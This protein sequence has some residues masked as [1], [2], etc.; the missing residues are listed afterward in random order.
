MSDNRCYL[1]IDLGTSSLKVGL[2]SPE[3]R[4]LAM[5]STGVQTSYPYPGWAEQYP[6]QWWDATCS[7]TKELLGSVDVEPKDIASIGLSAHTPANVLLDSGDRVLAPA[8]FWADLRAVEQWERLSEKHNLPHVYCLP[9][10]M[11]WLHENMPEAME[12]AEKLLM[13]KDFL[14]YMLTGEHTTDFTDYVLTRLWKIRERVPDEEMLSDIGVNPDILPQQVT[15]SQAVR[16]GVTSSASTRTG[17][18]EGTPVVAGAVDAEC[19][20]VGSGFTA[21]GL[22]VLY[23]GTG[24]GIRVSMSRGG[25]VGRSTA[26]TVPVEYMDE[27]WWFGSMMGIGGGAMK[28]FME[29]VRGHG[30]TN[31][32]QDSYETYDN[33][34]EG[35]PAGAEGLFFIPHM[36]GERSP[37]YDHRL[38]GA[39]V[40]LRTHHDATHIIRAIMEG[41]AFNVRAIGDDIIEQTGESLPP[42]RTAGGGAQS[43]AWRK[44][45]SAVLETPLDVMA[46]FESTVLGAA[47]LGAA[48]VGDFTS[49]VEACESMVHV[50][51]R[52]EPEAVLVKAYKPLYSRYRQAGEATRKLAVEWAESG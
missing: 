50:I 6:D 21:P 47:I 7:A 38:S 39:F 23:L 34:A 29:N 33:W 43:P 37:Y 19:N 25:L 44:I 3:G 26:R 16:G 35:V 17:L 1:G 46:E 52:E 14:G 36:Q 51:S 5:V 30:F 10:R 2:F 13:P 22:G 11:L 12:K 27:L 28:W 42:L 24:A 20:I 49:V 4:R 9:P 48:G 41:V 40:G 8:L 15:M 45:L 32:K 18:V 31:Q